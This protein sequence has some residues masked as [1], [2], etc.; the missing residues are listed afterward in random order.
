MTILEK[1]NFR[2]QTICKCNKGNFVDELVKNGLAIEKVCKHHLDGTKSYYVICFIKY[3]K[4]EHSTE[5]EN[6]G[7][8]L[9][10]IEDSEWKIF[11]LLANAAQKLIEAANIEE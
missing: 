1:D 3:N 4:S 11:K 8:N 7:M 6:I 2:L 10:D 9:L 5:F